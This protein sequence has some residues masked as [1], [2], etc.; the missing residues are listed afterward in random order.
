VCSVFLLVT[1]IRYSYSEYKCQYCSLIMLI[2]HT[3][4][5]HPVKCRVILWHFLQKSLSA[6]GMVQVLSEIGW[7]EW[8]SLPELGLTA[9][10]AKVDTG[11]K[12]SCLHTI[13]YEEYERE[14]EMW[15]SF[16]LHPLQHNTQIVKQCHARL[17]DRRVITDSGGHKELRPVIKTQLVTGYFLQG[18]NQYT[19]YQEIEMTLTNRENMLFRMLL[20]RRALIGRFTVNPALSFAMGRPSELLMKQLY[21]DHS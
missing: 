10:K 9:I 2:L 8:V 14:G 17:V 18:N 3:S 11:A 5:A 13:G 16:A 21:D 7:R 19:H 15:I 4:S 12:T 1:A 20:G 6:E